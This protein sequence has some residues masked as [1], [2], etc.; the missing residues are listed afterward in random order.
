MPV[1][2]PKPNLWTTMILGA[3][4]SAWNSNDSYKLAISCRVNNECFLLEVIVA[5]NKIHVTMIW[6][7]ARCITWDLYPK[8]VNSTG[9]AKR[10]Q[11]PCFY[12]NSINEL[13]NTFRPRHNGRHHPD[14]TF[15]CIFLNDDIWISFTISLKF[16]PK[17]PIIDSPAL[18]QVMAWHCPDDKPL[19]EP[20]MVSLLTHICVTRPHWVTTDS[21]GRD[22]ERQL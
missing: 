2:N 20:M 1:N 9:C 3:R 14:D 4:S 11:C 16:V 5:N 22:M 10:E 7:H 19:S 18:V 21:H 12:G 8:L 17:C 15:K 13:L 6:I